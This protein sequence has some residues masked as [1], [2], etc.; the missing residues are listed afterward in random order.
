MNKLSFSS[1]SIPFISLSFL[2]LALIFAWTRRYFLGSIAE[3]FPV[4]EDNISL[5]LSAIVA[6]FA[7]IASHYAWKYIVNKTK[8]P[9]FFHL[10]YT[11][12]G[13]FLIEMTVSRK[14]AGI[15][16][17]LVNLILFFFLLIDDDEDDEDD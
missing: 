10:I 8:F 16:I 14:I 15:L 2:V 9:I 11:V 13:Y 12:I 17:G 5:L 7:W 1:S 6:L 4:P 3:F